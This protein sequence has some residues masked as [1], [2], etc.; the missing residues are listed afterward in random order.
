MV[1]RRVAIAFPGQGV[2]PIDTGRIL[3]Q[4]RRQPLVRELAAHLG[5]DDWQSIDLADTRVAQ[6]AVYT[7]SLLS[8]REAT[9][10]EGE[11]GDIAA[12]TGHSLGELAAAAFADAYSDEAGLELAVRRANVGHSAQARRIGAMAVVMRLDAE[13]VEEVRAEA[14]GD[15]VLVLAVENG[16][17]QFVLSGDH[18]A[19]LRAIEFAERQGG[20][21]RLLSIGGAYHSPLLAEAS[22]QF[23]S[24][25]AELI[26]RDPR[27]PVVSSTA[28]RPVTSHEDLVRVLGRSL[29]LPVRWPT[30]LDVLASLGISEAI[31]TGPGTTLANLSRFTRTIPVHALRQE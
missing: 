28:V 21:S 15:D 4:H 17:R 14:A 5:D 29:V 18:P 27:L 24:A 6:P 16:P 10:I 22:S 3:H 8:A 30:V 19:V 20:V 7:A 12:V 31:D 26:E 25:A 1:T 13:K 9:R 11:V 23:E 2:D